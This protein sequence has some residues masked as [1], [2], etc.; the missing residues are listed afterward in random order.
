MV[1]AGFSNKTR[2]QI[3]D[4]LTK[5]EDQKAKGLN[6]DNGSS[7]TNTSLSGTNGSNATLPVTASIETVPDLAGG[8]S[9]V[10]TNLSVSNDGTTKGS[11]KRKSIIEGIDKSVRSVDVAA[12]NITSNSLDN[13]TVIESSTNNS[14]SVSLTN[15]SHSCGVPECISIHGVTQCSTC[16]AIVCGD[17]HGPGH[18]RHDYWF[19]AAISVAPVKNVDNGSTVDQCVESTTAVN[20]N[21]IT[22]A[23]SSSIV[24]LPSNDS[25]ASKVCTT[26]KR[27]NITSKGDGDD[28]VKRLRIETDKLNKVIDQI[29]IILAKRTYDLLM[30]TLDYSSYDVEFLKSLSH[31]MNI[32]LP[33]GNRIKRQAYLSQLVEALKLKTD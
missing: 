20:S 33:V 29:N 17:L 31:A 25:E 9:I 27:P 11:R 2:Q 5:F 14:N 21:E 6:P 18:D 12:I 4:M 3:I 13:P 10:R 7:V 30:S 15:N 32:N 26:I 19:K 24:H 8:M 22:Y 16:K 23:Q 1:I 28:P